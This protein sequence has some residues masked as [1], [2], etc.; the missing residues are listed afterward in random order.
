MLLS[1]WTVAA[2]SS[3]EPARLEQCQTKVGL[4]K[5]RVLAVNADDPADA[6]AIDIMVAKENFS[7]PVLLATPDIAGC[8]DIFYRYLF[9]RRRDLGIPTSFLLDER[10]AIVKVYQNALTPERLAADLESV[11]KTAAER[12]QRALPFA[13]TLHQGTFQRSS[14]L[15]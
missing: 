14:L 9:D 11:P 13:G 12:V 10:G 3:I 4:E 1:F 2:A 6:A 5:L 15:A 8:Y 7:F